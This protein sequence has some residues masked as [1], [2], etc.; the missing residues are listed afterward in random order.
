MKRS[1]GGWPRKFG[2]PLR[3]RKGRFRFVIF[4]WWR[5]EWVGLDL[6]ADGNRPPGGEPVRQ[7][8]R[9]HRFGRLEHSLT[10]DS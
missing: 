2:D 3:T 7:A 10:T 9:R 4:E 1:G 5:T 8:R 6:H